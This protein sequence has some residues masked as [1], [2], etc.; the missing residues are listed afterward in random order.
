[1]LSARSFL[2][3]GAASVIQNP[4]KRR[5]RAGP[6]ALV[7]PEPRMRLAVRGVPKGALRTHA[8]YSGLP[9]GAA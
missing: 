2:T 7:Q 4:Q 5:K 9:Y 3:A 1:M 8:T 6:P